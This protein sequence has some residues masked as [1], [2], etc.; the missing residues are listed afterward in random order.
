[1]ADAA[2]I[3]SF[4]QIILITCCSFS[5][6]CNA[7]DYTDALEKSILFFE[8]QRSGVLPPNQRLNWRG[9][10]GLSDGSSY[11]VNLVGGYY[12]AG[13]NV[14]FGLPMAFSTT[15]LAWSVIEFGASM[16]NQIENAKAA[17]RWSADYLLKAA[18]ATPGTLYVQ[19]GDPNLDHKCWERPEDMDTPR[20][21]YKVTTKNPGSDLAAET[22]AALASASIVFK[23]SDPSY[24][25]KL[26]QTAMELVVIV[27]VFDFADRFRGSYSDS[28]SSAVCPFYCS[29]SGYQG[30]SWIHR[31][32]Q[33][34]SY[35]AYIKSNGHLMG[36]DNDDYSFSWDDKR[37]GTKILL[38]KGFLDK[39]VEEFQ[40]FK[41]HSDNYICSLIPGTSRF[42]AQYTP[43]GLLY[44]ASESN[45]QYVTSTS[46]LLL[47]YAKYLSSNGGIITCGGS[48]VTVE[49]LI[50]QAKKQVDYILGDNPAKTSYMVG[51]G[52]RYPQHVHHRGSSVPSI[53][54]HPDHISCNDGFQY[55]Y[56]S[57]PN[58]N[59]LIGAIV[60]GPDNRDNFADDRNNYQQ[61][62]PAT[63]INAP[64]VGALAFFSGKN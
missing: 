27:Q 38:S 49:S 9:N 22:A 54:A 43:G 17:I 55:L 46:F 6:F 52:K 13:D 60:G 42:Q 21:V 4:V 50:S 3:S 34:G 58:P 40:L 26:L 16:Q 28:L 47:T 18:T 8:G 61:S 12:D 15:L 14:K 63:Y 44:K 41:A 39:R 59:V 30:A 51:F 31:A 33:N 37:A 35:L 19:V 23:N 7:Q 11:H 64:F 29:Y 57:S 48:T 10:S 56:S 2:K 5:L 53:H 45:L 25:S 1:M 62:E 36:A 32:S 24:S 20:N